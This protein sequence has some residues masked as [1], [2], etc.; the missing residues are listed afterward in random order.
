MNAQATSGSSEAV[1]RFTRLKSVVLSVLLALCPNTPARA[2]VCGDGAV[3][4]ATEQCDLTDDLSCPGQCQSDCTC[5]AIFLNGAQVSHT[6]LGFGAE[7][8]AGDPHAQSVLEAL[9]LDYVRMSV[10]PN[11]SQLT[12]TAPSGATRAEIDAYISTNFNAD[13]SIRLSDAQ[14]A[15]AMTQALDIQIILLNW[16][17]PSHWETGA[18]DVKVIHLEDYARF[19][20]S[21]LV[22]LDANGMRPPLVELSN[23][24]DGTWNT[25]ISAASYNTLVKST[26]L[27]FD[28]RG[29]GDVGILGPGL[30]FLDRSDSGRTWVEALDTAGVGGIGR[31]VQPYL[32]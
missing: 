22:Y 31:M 4:P 16:E 2:A 1:R 9:E 25:R 8:W 5:P 3:D 18:G 14:A 21:L 32:G 19:W 11:W 27:E 26:R 24:P 12:E 13:F 23:E 30:A 17:V 7:I 28:E 20:G 29:F 10:G 6:V 15:W